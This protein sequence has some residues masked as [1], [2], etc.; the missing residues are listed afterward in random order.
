MGKHDSAKG[1]ERSG[2]GGAQDD[3]QASLLARWRVLAS[4]ELQNSREGTGCLG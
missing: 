1:S 2:E 4:T 3:D